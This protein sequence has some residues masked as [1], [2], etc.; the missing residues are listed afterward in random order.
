MLRDVASCCFRSSCDTVNAEI[1]FHRCGQH[2]AS[3]IVTHLVKVVPMAHRRNIMALAM[4]A[5]GGR[6]R[7]AERS[8][9]NAIF[10]ALSARA[11]LALIVLY[12]E[13]SDQGSLSPTNR[14]PSQTKTRCSEW[15]LGARLPWLLM[16]ADRPPLSGLFYK[17]SLD[18]R[19]AHSPRCTVRLLWPH[20][21][22]TA[23]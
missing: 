19:A 12:Q 18:V 6:R 13:G 14:T 5:L 2:C 16:T 9:S 1:F 10:G 23:A 15:A 20:R 21:P 3:R 22:A 11:V 7:V 4:A 17:M 8:T